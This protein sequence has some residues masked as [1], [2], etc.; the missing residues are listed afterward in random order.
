MSEAQV[1]ADQLVRS[2]IRGL[3]STVVALSGGVDSSLVTALAVE[4]LGPEQVLAVTATSETYLEEEL[5]HARGFAASLGVRHQIIETEELELE[6]FAQ[7]PPD[8][9]YHCKKELFAQLWTLAREGGFSAVIDGANRDD[10]R[11]FRPGLRASDEMGVRHPLMEAG[12]GK[13]AV[14]SLALRLGLNTWSKPAMACLSSR[15]PYGERITREKLDMVR[16]AERYLA[17]HGFS[18]LRVRHH[19]TTARIEIDQ[20]DFPRLLEP[21]LRQRALG[22]LEQLGYTYVTL[23]LAGFRSGSMNEVLSAEERGNGGPNVD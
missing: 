12:L 22:H 19:G 2:L 5:E 1:E 23:D 18:P 14:R 8:R 16:E 10:S 6:E 21:E 7:N 13:E 15:F 3:G 4:E 11:D 17:G 20:A 9:C